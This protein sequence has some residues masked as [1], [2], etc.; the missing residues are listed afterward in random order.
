MICECCGEAVVQV[1]ESTMRTVRDLPILDAETWLLVPR[2][3]LACPRCGPAWS[4]WC[5]W[6]AI[7]G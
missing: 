6:G 7:H 4:G 1:H 3:R 2:R 5:G